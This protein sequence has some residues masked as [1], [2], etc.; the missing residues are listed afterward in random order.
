MHSAFVRTAFLLTKRFANGQVFDQ[1]YYRQH[2]DSGT[3]VGHHLEEFYRGAVSA[4]DAEL[5]EPKNR[6]SGRNFT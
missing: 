2:D 6:Q 1:R 3:H 5:G 4:R